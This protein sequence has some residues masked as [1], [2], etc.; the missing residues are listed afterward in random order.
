MASLAGGAELP[1]P[2]RRC[3][4]AGGELLRRIASLV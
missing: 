4:A 1:P 3:M 2:V